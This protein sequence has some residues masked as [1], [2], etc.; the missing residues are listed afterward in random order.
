MK[1]YRVLALVFPLLSCLAIPAAA[2][3]PP[4]DDPIAQ[5]LFPPDLIMKYGGEIGLD[6]RQRAA[7]KDAVQK[8]QAKFVDAQWD[9]QEESQKMV[10]LLD[11]RP[12]DETA[13]LAQADKVMAEEREIKKTQLSL[14]IRLKN[15]LTEA[16]QA[17]LAELRGGAR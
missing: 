9:L 4:A 1:G 14:L 15:L 8:A 13:V 17:R 6:E 5:H 10:R 12:I 11:A 3:Q 7:V 16:Q 2:Q